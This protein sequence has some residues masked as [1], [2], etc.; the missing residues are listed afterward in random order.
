MS[1]VFSGP[2]IALKDLSSVYGGI[3]TFKAQQ[4]PSMAPLAAFLN[5]LVFFLKI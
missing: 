1:A 3:F 2:F 4:S 5:L